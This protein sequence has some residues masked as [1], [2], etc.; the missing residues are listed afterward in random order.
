MFPA[1]LTSCASCKS[2]ES[3]VNHQ[4]WID[5]PIG[6]IQKLMCNSI[7]PQG[8][9]AGRGALRAA[10]PPP[11]HARQPAKEVI[12][13]P[14]NTPKKRRVRP[15]A[16]AFGM[17]HFRLREV[18]ICAALSVLGANSA[19]AQHDHSSSDFEVFV[20]AEAFHGTQQTR[21]GDADPWID[22]DVVFGVTQHQF[23]V[24][25]EYYI[26]SAERD[27]ERF[28]M[29]FE[30]VPETLLWLGRFHQT[31]SAWNTEHH[32]G[33][34]LQTDITR[35]YIERWEDEHGIIPQHITG[36]L[37]ESRQSIGKD[38]AIQLSGGIGAAPALSGQAL[39]AIDLI[40]S[41]PGRH[42]L[43]VTGR[44]AY[45][46][47]YVGA[48]SAGLLFGHDD[49]SVSNA[50]TLA[51]L[52]S[53][54]ANLSIYGAYVDWITE[55]WRIVA[56]NYYVDVAMD[57]TA[58]N[59]SFMSGYLQIERQLPRRF[60]VFG[61][62]EDSSRMQESRYVA[63]FDDADGDLEIALQRQALGV[64]WDYTRRQALTL[65]ISHI[66]SLTQH[67]N[68]LRVQWSAAIP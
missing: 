53:R 50:R 30:F 67:S 7:E 26:S 48:S 33:Q 59:E 61:R 21:L 39:D 38:G 51:L 2:A 23:R 47:E 63:L 34:Y 29:G 66:V 13:V 62:V 20:A 16:G 64:R 5:E 17:S 37:F 35:P 22:A 24:F 44:L 25:G 42:R 8:P 55:P 57:Q 6:S 11:I 52:Q 31:G 19:S 54:E 27:L 28:Q 46:P 65:E 9:K 14:D 1:N 56:A 12:F 43:S 18:L 45:L 68:E 4:P 36:A 40:G 10:S 15:H 32:H 58:R 3:L 60:T 49:L 41:N